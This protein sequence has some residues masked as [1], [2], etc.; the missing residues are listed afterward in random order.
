M[1][2]YVIGGLA[3]LG[4]GYIGKEVARYLLIR[5]RKEILTYV[6]DKV[7]DYIFYQEPEESLNDEV[8]ETKKE[9]NDEILKALLITYL[10][11]KGV[12]K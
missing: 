11:E 10:K 2:K 12:R 1:T 7:L 9:N 4:A 8:E 3:V 5:Y 6:S